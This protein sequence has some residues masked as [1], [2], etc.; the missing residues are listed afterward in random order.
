LSFL[1]LV[2]WMVIVSILLWMRGG[3]AGQEQPR[4]ISRPGGAAG[5]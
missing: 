1:A 4:S 5:N 2:V 3:R